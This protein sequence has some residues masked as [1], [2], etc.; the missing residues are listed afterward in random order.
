MLPG[1]CVTDHFRQPKWIW[2]S[3]DR[4]LL[5]YS[6]KYNQQDATLYNILYYWQCSTC[7]RRLFRPSSVAQN[8]THTIWYMSSLLAATASL[9]YTRCCVY[10]F[11]LLM[12]G[13]ETA[14]NMLS[15]DSNKEYCITLHLVSCTWRKPEWTL[16]CSYLFTD[17]TILCKNLTNAW[18]M[19][20]L[21]SNWHSPTRFSP[22][23]SFFGEW[24]ISWAGSVEYVSKCKDQRELCCMLLAVWHVF[25]C[26]CS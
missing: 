1:T 5:M 23:G 11:E 7:F 25:C 10:I 12:M 22:Q 24:Y 6:F 15:I 14:Y 19:L 18:C 3:W 13:G 4:A 21:Y 2:H 16:S 26:L 8:C 20:I 9:T 17:V